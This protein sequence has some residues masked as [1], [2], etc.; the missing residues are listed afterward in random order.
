MVETL[1]AVLTIVVLALV[2]LAAWAFPRFGKKLDEV[3]D[4]LFI[5]VEE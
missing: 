3:T 4:D 2:A 5:E 1:I